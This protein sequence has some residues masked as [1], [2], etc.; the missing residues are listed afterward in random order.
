MTEKMTSKRRA[1]LRAQANSLEPV[2]QVGKGGVTD[3]LIAQVEDALRVHEL[4]KLK[5]LR[6][7]APDTAKNIA[8]QI[9]DATQADVVQ[10]IGGVM[11]FYKESPELREKEAQ[12]KKREKEAKTKKILAAKAAMR[13]NSKRR[14]YSKQSGKTNSSTGRER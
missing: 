8:V 6:E 2:F 10:V 12:K 4:I 7:S 11:V 9:S 5:V 1:E 14:M 13:N 3:A